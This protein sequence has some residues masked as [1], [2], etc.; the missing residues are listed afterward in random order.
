MNR[1][2]EPENDNSDTYNKK[3]TVVSHTSILNKKKIMYTSGE[4]SIIPSI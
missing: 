2:T 1:F 4:Q 3:D